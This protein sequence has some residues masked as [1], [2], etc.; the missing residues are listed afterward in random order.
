MKHIGLIGGLSPE[1]T[2]HYYE[3]LYRTYNERFG[4]LHFPELTIR[5][6]NL[7][8]LAPHFDTDDWESVAEIL[9]EALDALHGAGC[10]FAAI[11]ANTPHNAYERLKDRS[12]LE[13]L[14]IMDASADALVADE[15]NVVGL[16]GT[17]PTMEYGFFQKSFADR[18][19]E[20]RIPGPEHRRALDQIIWE[21]LSHGVVEPRSRELA[22][23]MIAQLENDGVDAVLLACTELNM[24]VKPEDSRCRQYDTAA[25]HSDAILA[26]ALADRTDPD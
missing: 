6:I 24:L 19:L 20:T 17:R 21:E 26:Y 8:R 23:A 4:K 16:L 3:Q 5:T 22:R 15:R 18:G 12:P 7:Q 2:V 25:I 9:L 11:L 14:T 1:S 10:D 13:I